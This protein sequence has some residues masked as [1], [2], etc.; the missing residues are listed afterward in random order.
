MFKS[1]YPS[2]SLRTLLLGALL[3]ILLL[4]PLPLR[5]EQGVM[6]IDYPDFWPF[7]TRQDNGEMT[8]FF[9]EIV[10]T[11]LTE[12]G[13]ESRWEAYPWGRCQTNVQNGDADAM[14][15][16]PTRERLEYSQTHEDPFY[17]KELKVFT[18]NGHPR[19][20]RIEK[21]RTIDDIIAG[22]FS[23][24]TYLGNGWSEKNLATRGVKIEA[25]A[26]LINVWRMLAHKRGDI[27]IEWP[28]AAWPDIR[29][30]G[31]ESEIVQT[32]VSL[33]SM[34]FHLLVRKGSPYAARLGEFNRIILRMQADGSLQ[35]IVN[36]YVRRPEN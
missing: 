10:T 1:L 31:L 15:T 20:D 23:V 24:V 27:V 5:A 30:A 2:S 26:Q 3:A 32:G 17:R 7:F 16:V 28:G 22:E 4:F 33:E 12:M 11:A 8:G 35:R 13:I 21:I 19:L 14:I 6:R 25:S 34:P 18:Y 29:K 9:Y 36:S